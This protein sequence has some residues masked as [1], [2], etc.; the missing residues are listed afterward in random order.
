M[1][2]YLTETQILSLL[3]IETQKKIIEE[4]FN[5]LNLKQAIDKIPSL[6]KKGLKI[7]VIISMLAGVYSLDDE[8]KR[9]LEQ[10]FKPSI[11]QSD[12]QSSQ[13]NEPKW[14]EKPSVNDVT[15]TIYHAVPG[16]CNND[17][18]H[19]AWNFRLNMGD[20]LSHRIVAMTQTLRNELGV[21]KGDVIMVKGTGDENWDGP[22]QVYDKMSRDFDN[23]NNPRYCPHKID[24]LVP[25]TVQRG[26]PGYGK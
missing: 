23:P 1:N 2:I 7:G 19:T 17:P 16:Q 6:L 24:F 22:W 9:A 14:A 20:V 5:G 8:Q 3:E 15:A 18:A 4:S 11:E 12:V 21:T 10:M 13:I 26:T 25:T